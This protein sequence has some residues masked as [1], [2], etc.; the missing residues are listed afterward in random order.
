MAHIVLLVMAAVSLISS[1]AYA[2]GKVEDRAAGGI[3]SQEHYFN[4]NF[5]KNPQ[6]GFKT[7]C[8]NPS[9]GGK[10]V[11]FVARAVGTDFSPG[12]EG[13]ISF[14]VENPTVAD[15][16]GKCAV[17][18]CRGADAYH[19]CAGYAQATAREEY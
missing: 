3:G 4:P 7:V 5:G 14:Y 11:G 16:G 15:G 1:F 10:I 12:G 17:V 6:A 18:G 8:I 9:H 13:K 2:E 19:N